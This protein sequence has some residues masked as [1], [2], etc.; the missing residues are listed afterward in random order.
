MFTLRKKVDTVIKESN[1]SFGR[2]AEDVGF[3]VNVTGDILNKVDSMERDIKALKK[4][5]SNKTKVGAL[6]GRT[7][8]TLAGRVKAIQDHLGISFEVKPRE[9]IPAKIDVVKVKKAKK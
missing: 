8:T 5:H 6:T 1:A 7:Y 9:V 3:L 4:E 2:V